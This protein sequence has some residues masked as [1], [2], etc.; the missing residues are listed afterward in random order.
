MSIPRTAGKAAL[1]PMNYPQALTNLE[2]IPMN[3]PTHGGSDSHSAEGMA[4]TGAAADIVLE[5]SASDC[6][7]F[8]AGRST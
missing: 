4:D 6:P 8:N 1:G 2:M 5:V 3:G 7:H